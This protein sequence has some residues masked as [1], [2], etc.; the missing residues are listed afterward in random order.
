MVPAVVVLIVWIAIGVLIFFAGAASG[1][2]GACLVGMI[3]AGLGGLGF[4]LRDKQRNPTV[5]KPE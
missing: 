1:N 3:F 2:F 4:W 5:R